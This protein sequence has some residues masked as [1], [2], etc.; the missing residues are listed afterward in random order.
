MSQ[1]VKQFYRQIIYSKRRL[2]E[3]DD[4]DLQDLLYDL[5]IIRKAAKKS[6]LRIIEVF[7]ERGYPID[8]EQLEE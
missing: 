2:R 4:L 8:T 6:C 5:F 7:R 1:A 3:Y